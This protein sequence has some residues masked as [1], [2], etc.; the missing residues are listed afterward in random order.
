MIF[1]DVKN[2]ILRFSVHA[3][4]VQGTQKLSA[5]IGGMI[6][7]M[8]K[9]LPGKENLIVFRFFDRFGKQHIVL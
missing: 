4:I 1:V 8:K 5:M 9:H 7:Y 6:G 3:Q 2:V